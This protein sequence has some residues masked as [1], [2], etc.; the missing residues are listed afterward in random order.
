MNTFKKITLYFFLLS[1][2][3]FGLRFFIHNGIRHN[4]AGLFNK[5]NTVFLQN[6]Y[7]EVIFVGSSRAECHFD[8]SVFDSI[9]G[10]KSYNIG[11]SGSNNSFTYGI[12][13]AYLSN[14]RKPPKMAIMNID[15]HFAHESSDTIYEFPRF[16]PYLSNEVLY[17]ELVKR[18]KR[19][20]AFKYVPYYSLPFLGEKYLNVALRGYTGNLSDYDK[21][22]YKG[23]QFINPIEYKTINHADTVSYS[24]TILKE[25]MDYLDSTIRLCN[26]KNI[27]LCFVVSPAHSIVS[28][29]IK[30]FEEH[31]GKF[32]SIADAANVPFLDYSLDSVCVRD[33]FFAD[34][35]HMKLEGA[36]YFSTKFSRDFTGLKIAK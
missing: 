23:F 3:M 29:R 4:K 7:H 11:V 28:K 27:Q 30:N 21:S 8:P 10:L 25:N 6:D 24:A 20:F 33:E 5:F 18:D 12:L 22:C 19:F 26:S 2:A 16:F 14:N 35:Y 1:G 31:I 15:Y 13:K 34:P 36:R 9:T 32:K 17:S